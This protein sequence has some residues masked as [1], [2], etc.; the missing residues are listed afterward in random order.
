MTFDKTNKLIGRKT[1]SGFGLIKGISLTPKTVQFVGE[2]DKAITM[3]LEALFGIKSI[4]PNRITATVVIVDPRTQ[5]PPP[6]GLKYFTMLHEVDTYPTLQY[7]DIT[8]WGM[9]PSLNSL[10]LCWLTMID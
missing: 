4:E 2:G 5:P 10:Y 6:D 9:S 3:T 1:R 8:F 7:M